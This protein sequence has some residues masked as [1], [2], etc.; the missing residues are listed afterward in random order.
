M[1]PKG[2]R[3]SKTGFAVVSR[4]WTV[5]VIYPRGLKLKRRVARC[6][7]VLSRARIIA[8][9]PQ[10]MFTHLSYDRHS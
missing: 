8:A 6:L 7:A 5:V 3:G 4:S 9:S 1:S 2:S 10:H